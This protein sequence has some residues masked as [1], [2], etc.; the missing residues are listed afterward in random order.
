MISPVRR[1][2]PAPLHALYTASGISSFGSQMTMLALPWL[3]L[4]TSGSATRTGLVFA[5]QVLPM[6]L[7]GF[8]GGEVMHRYGARRVMVVAD[9]ARAPVVALVPILHTVHALNFAV[10]LTIV[11]VLGL[12]GVPYTASQ[13]IV[14]VDLIGDDARALSRANSVLEGIYSGCSFAGPAVAGALIA[15]IGTEQVLWI[16]AVSFAASWG[17][18][19]GL[20]PAAGKTGPMTSHESGVLLGLR[21]LFADPFLGRTAISTVLFGFLLRVLAI[22]LPLLAYRTFHGNVRLAGLLL[23]GSGAG[24]LVGSLLSYLVSTRMAPTRLAGASAVLLAL[25]L[26]MLTLPVPPAVLVAAVAITSAAVPLSNAPYFAL[27]T[28]RVP[29]EHRPKVLQAVFTLSNIAGPLGFLSAGVLMDRV[30]DRMT[31]TL[32]ALLATLAAANFLLALRQLGTS[33][34]DSSTSAFQ[35]STALVPTPSSSTVD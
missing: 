6:A 3:V 19:A 1:G 34:P 26:W 14:A 25:P 27:L 18:L 28:T 32:V 9:A 7:L 4:E 33:A 2:R 17:M 30:G 13:H 23:A 10:L 31:L 11:A 29:S 20:V 8:L 15:L 5:V 12:L 21:R 22:A 35:P 16:D 24:A